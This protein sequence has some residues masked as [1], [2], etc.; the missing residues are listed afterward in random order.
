M[1]KHEESLRLINEAI[2]IDPN[3]IKAYYR[4]G[5][6]LMELKRFAEAVE[7]FIKVCRE[8]P[9]DTEA[10]KRLHECDR[11]LN[12]KSSFEASLRAGFS[13]AIRVKRF[14]LTRKCVEE[15]SVDVN[16]TGP[17][18]DYE[19]PITSEWIRDTLV[20]H[21]YEDKKLNIKYAYMVNIDRFSLQ[22]LMTFL[23]FV[24]SEGMLC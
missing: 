10:H 4:R 23:D 17:V 12:S 2:N 1:G 20:P 19:M 16:Y 6:C 14:E 15:L 22:L 9:A 24:E 8:F 13:S 5:V 7:D 21:F 3:F 18:V 11:E